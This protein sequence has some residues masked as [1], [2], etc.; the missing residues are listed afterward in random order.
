MINFDMILL[1]EMLDMLKRDNFSPL[2][3]G[4]PWMIPAG[5]WAG[6]IM[7]LILLTVGAVCLKSKRKRNAGNIIILQNSDRD[8]LY[9]RMCLIHKNIHFL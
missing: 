3:I 6:L 4:C 7:T 5:L 1:L 9:V 2:L 8:M